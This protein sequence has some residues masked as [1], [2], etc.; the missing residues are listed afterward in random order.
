MKCNGKIKTLAVTA[1]LTLAFLAFMLCDTSYV[2]IRQSG[3]LRLAL[4]F[5]AIGT[6]L[7]IKR[8]KITLRT[9]IFLL[10]TITVPAI[11]SVFNGDVKQ[12]VIVIAAAVVGW[13]VSLSFRIDEFEELFSKIMTFLSVY[14]L[15]T[16]ALYLF[17]PSFVK[18]FPLIENWT[19]IV[20][21]SHNMF[22]SVITHCENNV[23]NYGIFW[24]PGAFAV[25]L[26]IALWIELYR[27]EKINVK[28]VAVYL[29]AVATTLSSLGLIT[30][31][32][33]VF[34]LLFD[35]RVS[36]KVKIGI[37]IATLILAAILPLSELG[38][39][40]L[41]AFFKK[42]F[43][44][45]ESSSGRLASITNVGK[46]FISSPI[47]GVGLTNFKNA[48]TGMG[49]K[50]AAFTFFNLLALNGV[51]G[52][53]LPITGIFLYFSKKDVKTIVKVILVL[54]ALGLFFSEAFEQIP[55]F[56]ALAF[57]GLQKFPLEKLV[58]KKEAKNGI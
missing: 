11:W 26:S 46:I 38:R 8:P 15:I 47:F 20:Y 2:M 42:F 31:G 1:L 4:N 23:R 13:A 45:D 44:M 5:L 32:A 29:L 41:K 49:M 9:V 19:D 3:F 14:S 12:V 51:I 52:A 10:G 18:C 34:G 6:L 55:I 24:E 57:Y 21:F 27:K 22:F 43:V 36:K 50:A 7:I 56:Y 37:V 17:V 35:K 58:K 54:F 48:I 25:F 40:I 30:A 53:F 28:R 16:F 39:G 33:L